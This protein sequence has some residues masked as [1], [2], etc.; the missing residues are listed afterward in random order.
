MSNGYARGQ[1]HIVQLERTV[2]SALQLL[3]EANLMRNTLTKTEFVNAMFGQG[4]Y[5]YGLG[6][7][8]CLIMFG[9]LEEFQGETKRYLVVTAKGLQYAAQL[10]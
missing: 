1:V 10:K 9:Y 2:Q 5:A 3:F 8:N 7:T 6:V 4:N